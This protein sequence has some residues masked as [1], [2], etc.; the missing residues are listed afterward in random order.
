MARVQMVNYCFKVGGVSKWHGFR[1]T[2]VEKCCFSKARWG[3]ASAKRRRRGDDAWLQ[4]GEDAEMLF[5]K[6]KNIKAWYGFR[7]E[8]I[9]K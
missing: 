6:A 5:Q 2:Q 9:V 8:S 7:Y 1:F 3:T 4:I